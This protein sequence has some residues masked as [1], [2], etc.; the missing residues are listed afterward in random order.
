VHVPIRIEVFN[1]EE[2]DL[3]KALKAAAI[4]HVDGGKAGWTTDELAPRANRYYPPYVANGYGIVREHSAISGF[5]EY[6][7]DSAKP[8]CSRN[9]GDWVNYYDTV[10]RTPTSTNP[11]DYGIPPGTYRIKAWVPGFFQK[12]D[13]VVQLGYM[14][15]VFAGPIVLELGGHISGSVLW[16]DMYGDMRPYAWAFVTISGSP[17]ITTSASVITA[18]GATFEAWVEGDKSYDVLVDASPQKQVLFHPPSGSNTGK[19]TGYVQWGGGMP[20]SFEFVET[21]VPVP[22]FPVAPLVLLAVLAASLYLLRW[23]K[24]IISLPK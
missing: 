17:A 4:S 14:T 6:Y 19:Q 16:T 20:A 11:Y 24:R 7:A 2:A 22:E 8:A 21:G 23:N 9:S 3:N 5:D 10:H 18:Q 15:T 13:V 12:N 1:T